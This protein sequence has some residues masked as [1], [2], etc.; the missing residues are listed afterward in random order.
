MGH[1]RVVVLLIDGALPLDAAMPMHLLGGEASKF[2]DLS[3]V[4]LDGQSI[5][6][7]GGGLDLAPSGDLQLLRKAQTVIVPGYARASSTKLD[8]LTLK[9]LRASAKRGARMV[10]LCTGAFALAQAGILDGMSATTHW[11][12]CD[13]LARQH[14]KV[15]VDASVLFVD[16]DTVLTSA[17]VTAGIDLLLHLLRKDLGGSVANHVARRVVFVPHREGD[18]AQF[19]HTNPAPSDDDVIAA[20]QQWMLTSLT[21]PVTVAQMADHVHMSRR[22]FHRRFVEKTSL[23]PLAWLHQQRIARTKELLETTS[24]S[25]EE[26][27]GQ[28]GLG[29]SANL[30]VH[31]HRNAHLSPTRYRQLFS[32][33]EARPTSDRLS[34]TYSG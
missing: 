31:F 27:A 4:T 8:P 14:P 16:N 10:S 3:T 17:G 30:R 20:A 9:A 22:N 11:A 24:L 26:I 23:T 19:I 15:S 7:S 29:S 25:I 13:E 28:V 33:D 2:Y 18:Q 34:A 12:S 5:A 32:Q 6:T 1:H 21:A